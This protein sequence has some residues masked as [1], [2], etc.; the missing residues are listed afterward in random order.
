MTT[1]KRKKN[2]KQRG[3]KTHGWGS[4]KKHRG[5]GSRGGRGMA[6]TGKRADHHKQKIIKKYGLLNY[7]GKHGF[8]SHK[9]KIKINAINI[10]YLEDKFNIL[11]K[12]E[13][14]KQEN[15]FYII[16]LSKLKFNKL[17]GKGNPTKKYK[18]KTKFISKSAKEKIEKAGGE[19]VNT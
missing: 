17:L 13:L 4:M 7:F 15:N 14:I 16:D 5:A 6:G 1:N 11:Q 19:I 10:S 9:P 3:S 12:K 18:I 2:T 8:T